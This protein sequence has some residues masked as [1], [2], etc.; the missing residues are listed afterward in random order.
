MEPALKTLLKKSRTDQVFHSHVSLVEPMG[1]FILGRPVIEEFWKLYCDMVDKDGNHVSGIAEAPPVVSQVRVDIDLKVDIEDFDMKIPEIL[2]E[3]SQLLT[4]VSAYQNTLKHILHLP[5][6]KDLICFVLQK[7][8]YQQ[9][10]NGRTFLKHGFHLHFPY[11][12]LEKSAQEVHL[13][14]RVKDLLAKDQPFRGIVSDSSTVVDSVAC[15]NNAWL[16]YGSKKD[17]SAQAY[18]VTKIY[19]SEQH[20]I[21]LN[22]AL[23]GYEL[24]DSLGTPIDF[25]SNPTYYL[26]RILSITSTHRT[27]K[28]LK[29]GLP[30]PLKEK[31]RKERKESSVDQHKSRPLKETLELVKKLLPMLSSDRASDR[32]DWMKVGWVLYNETDGHPDA[33]DL[34]CEFSSRCEDKYDENVCVT[35]W[36]KMRKGNA[37]IGTLK[38]YA[39]IDSP[40]EYKKMKAS[41][42]ENQ[43]RI[44]MIDGS[45]N[46]IAKVLYEEFG[47]EFRCASL[48]MDL[49]YQFKNNIWTEIDRGTTLRAKISGKIVERFNDI[50]KK[51]CDEEV[52]AGNDKSIQASY[53]VKLKQINKLISNLKSS[54]FKNN[55][56]K[57]AQ[58]V[59]Y[60]PE[61]KDL[62]DIN[63]YLIAFK[64]GVLDLKTNNFRRGL[65]EDYLSK[66][67]PINYTKYS[68]DSKEVQEVYAILE[69]ILA[70]KEVRQYFLD[71]ASEIFVG[72]NHDK[73]GVFWTGGGDNGKTIL[74]TF[75]ERMLGPFAVKLETPNL[76]GKKVGA[77]NA[78]A[79]LARTGGGVRWIA[80]EE[81]EGDESIGAGIFKHLTGNDSYFARDLFERGKKT[82]E[83]VPLFKL[84]FICNKLPKFRGADRAVFNRVKVIPFESTFC[85]P[86]DPAPESVEEQFRT[87]RFPMDRKLGDRIPD[88]VEAFAY[89][90]LEHRKK[91]KM[92]YEPK[93]IQMATDS[94]RK[95]NDFYRKFMEENIMP[96]PEQSI[97]LADLY[98]MFTDWFKES[99]RG[100]PIPTKDDLEDHFFKLWKAPI[101]HQKRWKGYR[102]RTDK[103]DLFVP[104]AQKT[105]EKDSKMEE[106]VEEKSLQEESEE[107]ILEDSPKRLLNQ[108]RK[109]LKIIGSHKLRE[110]MA[111]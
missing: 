26:P 33:L 69:K 65:P 63:P 89:I 83:I 49:W 20:E 51:I 66:C 44:A 19:N 32:F 13:I 10:K 85:R 22:E 35:E 3:D 82:K 23:S 78:S 60:D 104:T 73:I 105:G 72:G 79:E 81:P 56:M 87:K 99:F 4:V 61:F 100:H 91:P 58:E 95:Q 18:K 90:L 102:R 47:D 74:Q 30:S 9:E 46:D 76:T 15:L 84:V 53:A 16:L 54:P 40:E 31:M 7:P 24:Y 70:D 55:V 88:L 50:R 93:K 6:A 39:G 43:A 97:T 38:Y 59:F 86:E 68:D 5:R 92:S 37:S 67:L 71:F 77:G 8:M 98:A 110:P 101:G 64:N 75:F 106:K 41:S 52:N 1:K 14:P 108:P 109:A 96:D 34:W 45:H 2:Y 48:S 107:E 42:V 28:T 27:Q 36:N 94:Y 62:L 12:F 103:D 25:H 29:A 11:I 111:K 17:A 80:V 21:S 57:E